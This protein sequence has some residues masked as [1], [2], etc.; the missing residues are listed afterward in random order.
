MAFIHKLF[1]KN[2]AYDNLKMAFK[3][4]FSKN[5]VHKR[6]IKNFQDGGSVTN[7]LTLF[8]VD[9]DA[10]ICVHTSLNINLAA[11]FGC[12]LQ[13]TFVASSK[14]DHFLTK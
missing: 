11:F 8:K 13:H 2:G 6:K 14:T 10:K 1:L 9:S 5:G 7:M 4:Q 3:N 12:N